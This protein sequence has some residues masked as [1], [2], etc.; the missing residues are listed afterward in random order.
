[1]ADIAPF[2]AATLRDKVVAEMEQEIQ[3]LRRQLGFSRRIEI[4]SVSSSMEES[5]SSI[6]LDIS[7]RYSGIRNGGASAVVLAQ[8]QIE[9]GSYDNGGSWMRVELSGP[10][11]ATQEEEE[12]ALNLEEDD[13]NHGNST[14]IPLSELCNLRICVG[15]L[16]QGQLS[17]ISDF[18]PDFDATLGNS[19]HSKGVLLTAQSKQLAVQVVVHGWP[20]QDWGE[21]AMANTHSQD[22]LDYL[23]L[24]L[25][26]R[27]PHATVS[28]PAAYLFT[29]VNKGAIRNLPRN[30]RAKLEQGLEESQ[31]QFLFLKLVTNRL[32]FVLDDDNENPD[33]LVPQVRR[34]MDAL[35]MLDIHNLQDLDQ[36]QNKQTMEYL[37]QMHKISLD[38]GQ[39]QGT[40][41]ACING[42]L[43]QKQRKLEQQRQRG[44]AK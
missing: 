33:A 14:G 21:I 6:G 44:L 8:G 38:C 3:S 41:E 5:T 28:F 15:G 39:Q 22:A 31:S 11:T 24:T 9:Q 12:K 26:S 32:R 2:V 43:L 16:H 20:V 13:C 29:D 25:P 30:V 27:Y 1:M 35:A 42:L 40:F 10:T 7:Q 18:R 23:A 4:L 17:S 34:V 36:G 19:E 37:I